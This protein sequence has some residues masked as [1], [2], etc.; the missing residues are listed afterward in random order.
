VVG[1][2]PTPPSTAAAGARDK[3]LHPS[4]NEPDY[5]KTLRMLQNVKIPDQGSVGLGSRTPLFNLPAG[6]VR[7]LGGASSD[8][9]YSGTFKSGGYNIGFIRIPSYGPSNTTAAINQ[10]VTEIAYFQATTDGLIVDEMHNPGG[11]VCYTE[12]LFSFLMPTP[13]RVVGFE[14]RATEFWIY[15]LSLN[16]TFA[17]QSG[18]SQD[19]IDLITFLLN[20][21]KT[22]YASNR[23]KTG[24]LP[25]CN[26]S[27]IQSPPT[28]S[29][30]NVF[31]YTKPIMLLTDEL[32]ASGADDFPAMFQ[33][34]GRG[35]IFGNRTMGAGGS[36]VGF[37]ATNYSEGL[38]S[39]TMS[40]MNRKLPIVTSDYPTAPYVENIGVRPD[41]AVDYMTLDNLL[42]RGQPFV[43]AF[44]GAMVDLIAKSQQQQ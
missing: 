20:Q 25:L 39:V 19:V 4:D 7:R 43:N 17:E 33:D 12:Q 2:V 24:P 1:P 3:A 32:S 6:F 5:M 23:G 35:P 40:Q 29:S 13:F 15:N 34:N 44:T 27:L 41:I 37:Q 14:I 18:A 10:F 9:F 30:G 11:S 38:T 8:V 31:A 26:T 28:D 42:T 21:I 22:A 16:A 36:V